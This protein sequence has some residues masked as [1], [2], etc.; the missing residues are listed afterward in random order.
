MHT[1]REVPIVIDSVELEPLE[2]T[3]RRWRRDGLDRL[4]VNDV[5][6]ARVGWLD[7]TTGERNMSQPEQTAAFDR[8]VSEWANRRGVRVPPV[9]V[10]D[11]AISRDVAPQCASLVAPDGHQDTASPLTQSRMQPASVAAAAIEPGLRLVDA[12]RTAA[13]D[14]ATTPPGAR[15]RSNATAAKQKRRSSRWLARLLG[16]RPEERAWR[17][18]ERGEVLVAKQLRKL[19]PRWHVLHSIPVGLNGAD[20][21]HLVIGPGGVFSLNAKHH[22]GKSIWVAGETFMVDGH[23]QPYVRNSRFEAERVSKCLS[24]VAGFPVPARGVIVPVRAVSVTVKENPSDVGVVSWKRVA[25]HLS[26][27]PKVLDDVRVETL[28]SCARRSSTWGHQ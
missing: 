14:L 3:A 28:F 19:G 4:Y 9:P 24:R 21:D 20:I 26:R 16:A 12:H 17:A 27:Q 1:D 15:V 6:G 18:G 10:A 7:L 22:S 11:A 8:T 5:S 13:N 23:R 2:L 25:K